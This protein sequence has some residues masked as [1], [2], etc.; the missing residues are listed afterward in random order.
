[1]AKNANTA[2]ENNNGTEQAAL[3]FLAQLGTLA[4][5]ITDLSQVA[6]KRDPVLNART[7]FGANCDE[8][9][10]LIKAAAEQGKFFKKLPDGYLI[11]FRNGNSAMQLNGTAH[12]K[13][14][15]AQAAIKFVE[16]AKA[17]AETGELDQAFRD[18]ARAARN[19]KDE[20]TA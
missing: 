13:V 7:K 15:D 10:K 18:S 17:G 16:A 12:F 6:V 14:G 4:T 1:M 9:V 11:T 5:A 20:A 19:A 2:A 3:G 8:T